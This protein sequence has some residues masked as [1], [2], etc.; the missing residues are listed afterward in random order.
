MRI[1]T[2]TALVAGALA[3]LATPRFVSAGWLQASP[4]HSWLDYFQRDGIYHADGDHVCFQSSAD[5]TKE[6]ANQP[7][8]TGYYSAKD[9]TSK[10]CLPLFYSIL[11]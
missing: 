1:S 6:V 4:H 11:K 8:F 7:K 2:S 9:P 10:S 3:L 5:I